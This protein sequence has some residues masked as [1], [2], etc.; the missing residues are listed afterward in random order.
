MA[1]LD[2]YYYMRGELNESKEKFTKKA[3]SRSGHFGAKSQKKTSCL[4]S[5]LSSQKT[6]VRYTSSNI[7]PKNSKH[8]SK[9]SK[10]GSKRGSIDHTLL[11]RGSKSPAIEEYFDTKIEKPVKK[12]KK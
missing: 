9:G 7:S 12:T 11:G 10:L 6:P 2:N 4:T 8:S 5:K 3:T 1:K